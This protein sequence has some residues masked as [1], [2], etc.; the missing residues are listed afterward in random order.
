M[1]TLAINPSAPENIMITNDG[2]YPELSFNE[3]ENHMR[4]DGSGDIA[5]MHQDLK[6]AMITVNAELKDFKKK[7]ASYVSFTDIP[8][9]D[10][11]TET[12]F[13][14]LYRAAVFFRAKSE[15]LGKWRNFDTTKSG[16]EYAEKMELKISDYLAKSQDYI[17]RLSGNTKTLIRVI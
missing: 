5:A 11:G 12:E 13:L 14:I 7:Y 15:I 10:Y 16:H 8:S 1:S 4:G 9:T 2:F 6:L 17:A 3:F